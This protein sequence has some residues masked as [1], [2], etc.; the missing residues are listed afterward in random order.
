MK[1]IQK[2]TA[3][4]QNIFENPII[5]A[6]VPDPD[7]IRIGNAYYMT[8]TTMHMNP[9]VPIMKS[10]DLVNWEI[11]NYVYD[12]LGDLDAQ[13]L[14]N[15]QNEYG[16][17]SWASSLR[18]HN[19]TYYAVFSSSIAGKTFIHRTQDI[20]NG[21]WT[22]STIGF[23]HDM[24]LLFDD[25]GRVYLVHGSGDIRLTELTSDAAAV[26]P[27]GLNQVIIPN[28]SLAA[29]P[30]VGLPAEGAHIQ[31]INGKYYV[32]LITW[33]QGAG[34]TQLVFRAD[35]ITGPYEGR[36]AL[37]Y[38]GIAQGG[39][40]D[41]PDGKWYGLLFQ[42]HGSVGRIPFIVPVTWQNNWPVFGVNGQVPTQMQ[43]PVAGVNSNEWFVASDEFNQSR[44]SLVWQ[45]NHNPDNN[46]WSLTARSGYLRL[47]TGR[48]STSILDARNSLTQRTVGPES[49]GRIAIDVSRMKNGDYA[50]LAALQKNYGLVGVKM[51]G[52][53]KSVVM[54]NGSSATPMEVAS[55]PLIQN[56]VY[57]KVEMD[58]KNKSDKAYFYYSLDGNR[59][60]AIGN[61]LQ[62]SYTIPH[63]MGYRFAIFNYATQSAGGYVDVDYF[64]IENR[65]TGTE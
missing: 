38:A 65:M 23:Y 40:V 58:F 8:S 13:A 16:K 12:T 31:K 14:R 57:L 4:D 24:S 29:G 42:D 7:A 35:R 52:N 1:V 41:T 2:N 46:L 5:W 6:D 45:W 50:G 33:P 48:T 44:L 3:Q 26:K 17:G 51:S 30:N 22:S 25:D 43:K 62:M 11:V 27:G 49:S 18:Y 34:R 15:G 54:V 28:A 55:V 20:E 19:G 10:Y 21:P 61:R 9:G 64:R 60:T 63:F 59:W 47:T 37:D 39:I 56:N 36:V 53:S 32:F